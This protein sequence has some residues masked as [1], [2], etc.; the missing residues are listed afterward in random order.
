MR[1]MIDGGMLADSEFDGREH[2]PIPTRSMA[3]VIDTKPR[4]SVDWRG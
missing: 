3:G 1:V 2:P 4:Q